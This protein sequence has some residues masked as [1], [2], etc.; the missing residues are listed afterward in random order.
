V[1]SFVIALS[2]CL[3]LNLAGFEP[4][5]GMFA[6]WAPRLADAIASCSLLQHFNALCRG[7]LDFADVA[8]Y[9]SV[10]IFSLAA[11]HL[12]IDNRKAS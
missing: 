6:A 4:V 11:A 8:Y 2:A 5:T 7:V 1:I 12:V 9:V 10:I 3:I